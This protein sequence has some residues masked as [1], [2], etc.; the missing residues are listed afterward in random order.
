MDWVKQLDE[1]LAAYLPELKV[2]CGEPMSRH[3]SFRIGGPAKRMAFPDSGEQIVLLLNFAKACG[4]RPLV[5][6]NGTNLLAPDTELDRLVIDTS[7]GLNRLERGEEPNTIL[8]EAGVSLARLADFACRQGLTGLEFAHGIP[9]SLGGAVT[10]DAGAYEGD[11]SMVVREVRCLTEEGE[12]ETV[13]GRDLDFSYRHSAFSDERRFI[14]GATLELK[15]GDSAAI[16]ALMDDLWNRRRHKQP[17]DVPSAGS[18]FKRP[19]GYFAAA[20]IDECKLKGVKMGG[21]Q[22]STKHAG[23][24]INAGGATCDD[25]LRLAEFVRE[26]VRRETGVELE[27]EVRTL[28]V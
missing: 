7:A 18:T 9:G 13:S 2:V 5:I 1:Q 21:A 4:A 20:L 26:T 28:G 3:T 23:F 14:L 12:R 15:S 22:V 24:L 16:K 8:A 11:M 19:K 10:M 25:V 27:L 6:G 17:L